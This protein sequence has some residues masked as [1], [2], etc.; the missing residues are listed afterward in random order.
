MSTVFKLQGCNPATITIKTLNSTEN[1][2]GHQHQAIANLGKSRYDVFNPGRISHTTGSGGQVRVLQRGA[3]YT[4]NGA[5][6][7]AASGKPCFW[8]HHFFDN[9]SMGIPV[10]ISI[11]HGDKRVY[12][13]DDHFCSYSCALAAIED[14]LEKFEHKRRFDA[15]KA[16]LIILMLFSEE[17]PGET[18][19]PAKDWRLQKDVGNGNLTEKEYLH[20]LK[21]IRLM[22]HPN[23]IFTPITISYDILK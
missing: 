12:M 14:E 10:K 23:F 5:P 16:K 22:Q 13:T 1:L 2:P 21:G 8:H 7:N 19:T 15:V 17:F 11:K 4:Q 9:P 3:L 20:S 6:Y 18:L